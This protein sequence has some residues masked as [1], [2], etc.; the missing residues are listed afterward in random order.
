MSKFAIVA[1]FE[2]AQG[3]MDAF[4]PLLHAHKERCLANEP[5]TLRFDILIPNGE[6][7]K[8]MAYEEYVDEKAFQVHWN[9]P[10]I[11]RIRAET[12]DMITKLSGIRCTVIEQ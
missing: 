8:V 4:L 6:A 10:Y 5:G 2:I 1:T 3:T 12:K 7:N 9:G 11:A